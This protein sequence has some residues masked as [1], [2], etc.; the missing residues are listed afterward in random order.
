MRSSTAQEIRGAIRQSLLNIGAKDNIAGS[1]ANGQA[2]G[3]V[4]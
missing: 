4:L 2:E 1:R 3:I